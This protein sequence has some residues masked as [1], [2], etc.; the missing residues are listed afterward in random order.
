MITAWIV[1]TVVS[2]SSTSWLID[3]FMT[4]WSSTMTSC[5]VPS[6]T[7]GN[8]FFI[9]VPA[10]SKFQPPRSPRSEGACGGYA[11]P[12]GITANSGASLFCVETDEPLE[13]EVEHQLEAAGV[14]A[15]EVLVHVGHR[16]R[17]LVLGKRVHV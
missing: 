6:A 17:E 4:D 16:V 12:V 11:T 14:V 7:S 9:D 5:A 8:H 2:K 10:R 13:D 15:F 1:V 3:T